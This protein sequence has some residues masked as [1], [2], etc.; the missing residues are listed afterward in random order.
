MLDCKL[1]GLPRIYEDEKEII[2]PVNKMSGVLYY[3]FI[4]KSA[5]RDELC[6][7]FWGNSND[8]RAK[9][10]L[11]NVLHKIRKLFKEEVIIS[12]NRTII[13]LNENIEIKIDVDIYKDNP[14]ENL[15]IYDEFL[16]GF[17]IKDT[18]EFEDWVF[19]LREFYKRK[20]IE[21]YILKIDKS[22]ASQDFTSLEK[23]IKSLLKMDPYNEDAFFDL[24]S[25]YKLIGR[26]DKL[27]N[28]YN[29]FQ[30][31]LDEELGV[32]PAKKIV[33]LYKD[34]L[35]EINK[36]NKDQK[37]KN[38]FFERDYDLE[39]IQN[40]L[41][42]YIDKKEFRSILISGETGVGKS[43]LKR[44]VLKRNKNLLIFEVACLKV[45][46]SFSYSV[47]IKLI[48]LI[49]KEFNIGNINHTPLWEDLMNNLLFSYEKNVHPQSKILESE[50]VFTDN[51][52]LSAISNA[53][54]KISEKKPIVIAIDDLQWIDTFSMK[55]LTKLLLKNNN[56][57]FFLL[58]VSNEFLDDN[59]KNIILSLN[60]VN[61]L[62]I[63]ELN[64]FT[65]DEVSNI[66]KKLIKKKITEKEID[67]IFKKS[68]GNSFFLNEYINLYNS[69]ASKN[70][71][72]S[73]IS[74]ILADKIS[75]L[76]EREKN[77]L[78]IASMTYGAIDIEL[79][80]KVL[81]YNAFDVIESINKLIKL[82]LLEEQIE[83][84]EPKIYFV[85][86]AYKDFVYNQI[87]EYSRRLIHN[88][89]GNTYEKSLSIELSN[90]RDFMLLKYHYDKADN[91]SKKLKY[92]I[93]ILNYYLNFTHE[94]F[95]SI[96]DNDL[97]RQV[98]VFIN[99]DKLTK[100]MEDIERKINLI[101][102]SE[103][104]KSSLKEILDYELSF[105]YC[106]GRYFIRGGNYSKGINIMKRVIDLAQNMGNA[107]ME[108]NG[109]KQMAIYS[110]QVGDQN[111]ML[112][113][114]IKGIKVSKDNNNN[115]DLGVFYRLYGVY[116]MTDGNFL[117]AEK[118]FNKSIDIF[119]YEGI[120]DGL[121]SISVAANY[122]YIGE[123]RA[124]QEKYEEAKDYYYKSIELC[125]ENQPT[126]LALFYINLGKTLFLQGELREMRECFYKAKDIV[127]RFDSYWKKPVLEAYLA[128]INFLD[129]EYKNSAAFLK[130]ALNEVNTIK[131]PRDI[132]CLYFIETI[133]AYILE[134]DK[135][136]LTTD[137][138]HVLEE[139]YEVYY[140]QAMKY[141][142]KFRDSAEINYLKENI[143]FN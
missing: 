112:E 44:E 43:M 133:I 49:E 128:L 127:E 76:N 32:S 61:K 80:I 121:N 71:K 28:E 51:L 135:S 110:I 45:E 124:A 97:N 78:E 70:L 56:K 13:S 60:E 58:T 3:L 17:Y 8:K 9:T 88:E 126:C 119:E 23:D 89:I 134:K 29:S 136:I 47:L 103:K 83:N 59:Q 2:L 25:Y 63:I 67:E 10:S 41:D 24:L 31:T 87:N 48:S 90:V 107:K 52:I 113:H 130:T 40:E 99:N 34:A 15:D 77:I 81:N 26:I 143:K 53:L 16:S 141:L 101:K 14:M 120:L 5:T 109:H 50:E 65:R 98:K 131:N 72:F 125:V 142:D 68:K 108:I 54:E 11:R 140:Y 73:K 100:Q 85:Y 104:Y 64:R 42:N 27:I 106:K 75:T 6:G 111:L 114:V 117:S 138:S 132:G 33:D 123:I 137:Y 21:N 86:S 102:A 115:A 36:D 7:L 20:H 94:L 95:P 122:N 18:Y 69:S 39:R 82:N 116:Y 30:R 22:F 12:N 105:L 118:L 139:S 55:T 79:I 66:C 19:E 1:F 92:E 96:N 37:V 62:N 84:G 35:K 91:K 4:K 57:I 46:Q 38:I 129:E 93:Y 74:Y